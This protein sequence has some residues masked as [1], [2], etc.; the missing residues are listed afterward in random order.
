[1]PQLPDGCVDFSLCDPPYKDEDISGN[2]LE[3]FLELFRGMKRLTVDYVLFFNNANRVYDILDLL[4]RPYRILIWTKGVVKYAWRWEPIFVYAVNPRYNLNA[5]IWSDHLPCQPLH[6]KQSVH[7]YEKP[8]KLI[9]QLVSFSS[10]NDLIL[11]PCSGSGV[12]PQA[13]IDSGRSFLAFDN[14]QDHVNIAN[15]RLRQEVFDYGT[16]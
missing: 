5:R 3:W 13:C 10:K 15:E 8:M 7:P 11:D 14:E 1:M 6:R 16:L 9:Q 12:V 4:G 2:Y